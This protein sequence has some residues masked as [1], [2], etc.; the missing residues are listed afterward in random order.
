L[1]ELAPFNRKPEKWCGQNPKLFD[2]VI[3]IA[4]AAQNGYGR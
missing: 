2:L 3:L 4:K 1:K